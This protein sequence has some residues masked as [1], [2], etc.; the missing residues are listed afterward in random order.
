MRNYRAAQAGFTL[1]ELPII[2][3]GRRLGQ[4]KMSNRIVL[5]AMPRVGA[6]R[7]KGCLKG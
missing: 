3:V 1:K 2:S 7:L 6:L 5:E 4:S